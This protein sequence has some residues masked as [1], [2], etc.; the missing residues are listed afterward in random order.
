[1]CTWSIHPR[2]AGSHGAT[3]LPG[4]AV[5][6]ALGV[7]ETM[8]PT[9]RVPFRLQSFNPVSCVRLLQYGREMKLLAILLAITLQPIFMGDVIQVYALD[10]WSLTQ[11]Q[12]ATFFTAIPMLGALGNV[13]GGRLVRY[14]GVQSFTAV[15]TLSNIV[16]WIGCCVSYQA[17]LGCAAIGFLGPART[18]G[19]S[20]A[21]TTIGASKGIPQGQLSGDRS[22]LI[23]ILKVLGPVVYG[24]L[25]GGPR[26]ERRVLLCFECL[27][28]PC[29]TVGLPVPPDMRGKTIGL[30]VVRNVAY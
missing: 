29:W 8:A 25:C 17:A 24:T 1:M 27:K 3:L 4:V 26:I 2:L 21:L 22:N 15:A 5:V 13:V 19:A 11:G 12:V 18:L 7:R 23:A 16:F 28:P 6:A 30:P 14:I 10:E 9:E 20:T